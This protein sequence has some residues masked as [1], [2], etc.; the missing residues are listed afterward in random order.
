MTEAVAETDPYRDLRHAREMT[1]AEFEQACRDLHSAEVQRPYKSKQPPS[2][3]HVDDMTPT[4]LR[5]F[6]RF[7]YGL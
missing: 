7:V 6:E 4:E 3:K 5:Q 2:T 1:E